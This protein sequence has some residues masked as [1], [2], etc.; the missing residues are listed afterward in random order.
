MFG[1]VMEKVRMW[2]SKVLLELVAK[3]PVLTAGRAT[4]AAVVLVSSLL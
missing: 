3:S 1:K 2:Y 4:P